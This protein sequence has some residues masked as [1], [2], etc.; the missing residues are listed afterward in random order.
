M[1]IFD[2]LGQGLEPPL[3]LPLIGVLSPYLLAPVGTDD[4]DDHVRVCFDRDLGDFGLSVLS[5]DRPCQR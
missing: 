5:V 1:G 4:R 3:R 2:G